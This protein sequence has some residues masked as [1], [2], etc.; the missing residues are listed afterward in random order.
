[1]VEVVR[2]VLLV[3]GSRVIS[4]LILIFIFYRDGRH[5]GV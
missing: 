4:V 2:V 3:C 1:M 5:S